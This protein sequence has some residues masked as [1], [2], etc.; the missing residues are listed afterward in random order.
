MYILGAGAVVVL[1]RVLVRVCGGA[2]LCGRAGFG[3]L[4]TLDLRAFEAAIAWHN[5]LEV[6][7]VSYK[8]CG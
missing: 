6:S 5:Q 1:V 7:V 4:G 2:S 3:P 8:K